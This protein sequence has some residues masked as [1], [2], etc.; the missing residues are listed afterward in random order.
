MRIFLDITRLATRMI[1]NSPT[2]I[3]RV[4]YAYAKHLLESDETVCVFTGLGFSG[5]VRRERALDIVSRVERAWR[6][7]AK[8]E[9]DPLYQHLR[10][11]LE[12]PIDLNAP[13]PFRVQAG[14]WNLTAGGLDFFPLR[15]LVRAR[16]RLERWVT[17]HN[18]EA[19]MFFN[20]S[21]ARLHRPHRFKWLEDAGMRSA[22]FMHDAIPIDYPE[23]CS[24]GSFDR[25]EQRLATVSSHAALVIVNSRYSQRTI[26]AALRARGARV[27]DI[28]VLPL[29]VGDA[30]SKAK[31][32]TPRPA[33]PY[34]L[35]V[36][37]IEPRKNLLF[38]LE[39]WRRLV[40]RHGARAPRLVI[41][42]AR[43][44]DSANIVDVLERSRSLAPFVAEASGL[45]D[46]GLAELMAGSAALVSPSISE[47]F[48]LP[49][50]ECL[51][52]GAPV[53]ASDIAAHR[54]VGG[55]YALFAD[56]IDG[57]A[58]VAAIE[59]LMDDDSDLRRDRLAKVGVYRPLTWSAHVAA[60]HDMMER[61][62]RR[63]LPSARGARGEG[64]A[65]T[66]YPASHS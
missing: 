57:P 47:G 17:R 1:R 35:Y 14:R 51:A 3:D 11:W 18:G 8:A 66:P 40:D 31:G 33:V 54:E 25:H 52:A 55:D 34:F 60:A 43:R 58:W 10:A 15:D 65:L 41:A 9:A 37:N 20:C 61:S 63:P 13:L 56:A 23:F 62:T 30:F 46:A 26:E 44:R 24:P 45:T 5:G 32:T 38:L 49:V 27:P 28:E 36:G 2:G 50:V 6:L 64:A 4:Q 59:Q 16:K 22:F 19:S 12:T 29:A 39:V 21:H 7:E 53:V 48:G 42:G